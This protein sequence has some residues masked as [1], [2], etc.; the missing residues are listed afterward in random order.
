MSCIAGQTSSATTT[1][2]EDLKYRMIH[3]LALMHSIHIIYK[4]YAT[5]P[6]ETIHQI[7][8]IQSE[9]STIFFTCA[10]EGGQ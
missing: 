4:I 3:E 10:D 9:H 2:I 5:L 6:Q 8:E 7:H 1:L